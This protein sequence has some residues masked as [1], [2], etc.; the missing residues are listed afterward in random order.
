VLL[1]NSVEEITLR[2]LDGLKLQGR[3]WNPIQPNGRKILALHGWLDNAASFDGIAPLLCDQGYTIVCLDLLG[4]GKSDHI[5][6]NL[7][8][9]ELHVLSVYQASL[10]LEWP[11]FNLLAHSMGGSIAVMLA[12]SMPNLVESLISIESLGPFPQEVTPQKMET[13][14]LKYPTLLKAKPK[15]YSSIEAAIAKLREK[16]PNLE[17]L[18]ASYIV[19]RSLYKVS[20]GYSF[21]HDQKLL[22]GSIHPWGVEEVKKFTKRIRCPFLT[23]WTDL[24]VSVYRNRGVGKTFSFPGQEKSVNEQRLD[25]MLPKSQEKSLYEFL[26]IQF[27]SIKYKHHKD[28]GL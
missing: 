18:S 2:L 16:N 27:E 9:V 7:Y 3:K 4:H 17:E 26:M 24:T 1:M 25:D 22:A 10:V 6:N 8:S 12:G 5:A 19:R 13:E 15:V 21:S 23:I 14:M 20:G 11:S 28:L